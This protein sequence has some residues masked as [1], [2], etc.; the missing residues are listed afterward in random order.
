MNETGRLILMLQ[1][2]REDDRRH[3]A[4]WRRLH[5]APDVSPTSSST[6]VPQHP[7]AHVRRLSQG[8]A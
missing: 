2:R 1:T 3:A 5:T 4:E 7:I 6:D 8:R